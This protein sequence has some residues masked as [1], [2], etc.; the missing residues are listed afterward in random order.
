MALE[1]G[2]CRWLGGLLVLLLAVSV[3]VAEEPA[4]RTSEIQSKESQ[5][6][7]KEKETGGLPLEPE[8]TIE[9]TTQEGTW[10]SLDVSP[11]GETILFE[12]LG[13]LYALPI[14]GGDAV[15]ITSGM[16]F[17]SQ[18][19]YSP[20]GRWIAFVSDRDGAD[21]LWIAKP[22]GTE[23]RKLTKDEQGSIISP[24]WTPD[25]NYVIVATDGGNFTIYELWMYHIDGGAGIQITKSKAD[26]KQPRNQQINRVG[27]VVSPDN[28]YLYYAR[29]TGGFGYNVQFP[30][31]Q[32][33]RRDMRTGDEDVIT[34]APGSAI[35]PLLSP[36]GRL[37]VY[38]TRYEAE[39]GLRVRNLD[40][41]EDRWLIYPIQRDD[42]ESA[43]T[44]DLLPGYGF[45]PAGSDV[46]LTFGGRIH[47]VN[48]E[49]GEARPIPFSAQV[50]LELGP[51]LNFP[52][53]VEEGPVRVRLIQDPVQSPDGKRIAFSAVSRLY[54]MELPD[55]QPRRLATGSTQGYKPA[56]SPDGR[57]VAYVSW[58]AEGGHIWKVRA[59]GSGEPLQLTSTAAF[60]TEP[61][62]SPDASRIVALRGSM[63]MRNQTPGEFGGLRIPLDLIW[64]PAEGG[65]GELIVP[66]RGM[67]S[68]HFTSEA[69]RILV[70]SRE[71]LISLRY[72]GTDRRTH[73][74]VTGKK[75]PPDPE[76]PPA[77]DVLMR[78][79]GAWALAQ[80]N[81]QLYVIAVPVVGGEPPSVDV[82]SPSVPISKLTDVG[83]DY[84]AWADGGRTITWAIGS[85]FFRRP[86]DSI[87][88]EPSQEGEEEAEKKDQDEELKKAPEEHESVE[89]F[90]VVLEFPRHKPEGTV[91]LRG[92]TLITMRGDEVISDADLVVTDNRI[93]ALGGR[94]QVSIPAAA[95]IF[96][97]GGH[98]IVPGFVDTHAHWEFRTAGVLEIPNWSL[99]A[100]LAYGVTTGL[101]VQTST[102]DYF[103]YQ[104]LVDMGETIGERA[105]STGPGVFSNNDFES[106][107]QIRSYL[108]RYKKHYRTPNLKSYMVGNRKQRQWVVKAARELEMMPTTEGGLDLML[109]LTHAIDGFHG[110]EH[111]LPVVP[112]YRDVVELFSRSGIA[113]T[114][115]LLV[116]YG[117]PWAENYFYTTSEVHDQPK[118]N[119][120]T[121]HNEIDRN[122]KRRPWFR[123]DEHSFTKT[124]AQAAN[125]LRAGGLVGVG[126]HGQLQ[127]LGYHWEM[128]AL[129][130]GGLTPMEVLR[131]ATLNGAKIIGLGQDLGSIEPGKL[132]DLVVLEKNPLDDIRNTNTVRYVMKNGELFAGD[133]LA[134]LWPVEKDPP[135]LRWLKDDPPPRTK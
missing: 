20:D 80:V 69:D 15:R 107:G 110:N 13:D 79:D 103:A 85:T 32:I 121:P 102:N 43:F 21:N 127:G 29:K 78:P 95:R 133:T 9:F 113:Y 31:W 28:R 100:N 81:G 72:D 132:A 101:D 97:V 57:W 124:A 22:D 112:L 30:L 86:F 128:W 70:Y 129:A 67:G 65:D 130:M 6:G 45:T 68:P 27:P 62:F 16:S 24:A 25:S 87:S 35:R 98:F 12:L 66:A 7:E 74:K 38:G 55:G 108:E 46:V 99:L 37:L 54:V 60:Y 1:R 3:G 120:F 93:V 92:A 135:R 58:S 109:D 91:V 83:A 18:P 90:E 42:Q 106:F 77:Q 71:G 134:E 14:G 122:T 96:Q 84:F 50:S 5:E 125:I 56:W 76:P 131:A 53:R 118:L 44:R 61:V 115:T 4:Q 2:D 23:P 49:S 17:D 126:A 26:P 89:S 59:D 10:L 104:D 51:S 63:Y 19:R 114:P 41:G 75:E 123:E 8:R 34:Q 88:F 73:L 119:R 36:D 52:R 111:A 116:L 64:I 40:S 105:Y 94:G 117:G 39:T 11:D 33:A 47:R 82:S 48:V